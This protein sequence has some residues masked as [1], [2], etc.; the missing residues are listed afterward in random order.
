M[1]KTL[2]KKSKLVL[3]IIKKQTT[4]K[5]IC[6]EIWWWIFKEWSTW[7]MLVAR[8]QTMNI[9]RDLKWM[10]NWVF[11]NNPLLLIGFG[12]QACRSTILLTKFLWQNT[13]P[14]RSHPQTWVTALKSREHTDQISKI[15]LLHRSQAPRAFHTDNLASSIRIVGQF[16]ECLSRLMKSLLFMICQQGS[17]ICNQETHLGWI[18]NKW[19]SLPNRY[20][21]SP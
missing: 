1:V 3:T 19:A 4:N 7:V 16:W 11:L 13:S 10:S 15:L 18:L 12:L 5:W 17:S 14:F 6:L 21:N 20:S 2:W 8:S 9:N